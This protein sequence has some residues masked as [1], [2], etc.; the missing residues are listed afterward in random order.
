[1]TIWYINDTTYF[2]DNFCINKENVELE[3]HGRCHL[4]KQMG[5]S[6]NDNQSPIQVA[7]LELEFTQ[8][9]FSYFTN[10]LSACHIIEFNQFSIFKLNS[11]YYFPETPPP[12]C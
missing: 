11:G 8:F 5:E 2:T 3:C 4:K 9:S 10:I 12:N 6:K 7:I 1:M